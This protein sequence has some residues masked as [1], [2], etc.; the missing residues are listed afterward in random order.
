MAK[1]HVLVVDDRENMVHLIEKVLRRDAS[2][3]AALSGAQA[4]K[5]LESR[6][7]DACCARPSVCTPAR[8]S[9]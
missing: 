7:F 4:L 6:A 5:A 8:N 9:S 3:H 2:T 1:P